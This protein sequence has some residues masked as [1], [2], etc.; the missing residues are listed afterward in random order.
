[1]CDLLW[2]DPIVGS[3]TFY[4]KNRGF[5]VTFGPDIT[6]NFLESHGWKLLIR[7]HECVP[8]GFAY[9]HNDQVNSLVIQS[10]SVVLSYIN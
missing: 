9:G 3:G 1:M 7:S 8:S 6:K 2:S 5:G 10:F 4:N